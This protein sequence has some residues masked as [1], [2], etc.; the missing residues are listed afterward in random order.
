VKKSIASA[1]SALVVTAAASI[2]LVAGACAQGA[3]VAGEF[4]FVFSAEQHL[5]HAN[6]ILK[7]HA[8]HHFYGHKQRAMELID[9][10]FH[11]LQAGVKEFRRKGPAPVNDGTSGMTPAKKYRVTASPGDPAE[12][13]YMHQAMHELHDAQLILV[14]QA[15][16]RFYGHK[17]KAVDLISEAMDELH[18]GMEEYKAKGPSHR[19]QHEEEAKEH[20]HGE[21]MSATPQPHP[22]PGQTM[23]A[24]PRPTPDRHH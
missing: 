3:P 11:E 16:G 14:K 5:E 23:R 6:A 24:H 15:E 8:G 17:R 10:A 20:E 2:L 18:D 4:Q 1:L 12:F 19:E 21:R 13:G 9:Q 22:T 7:S